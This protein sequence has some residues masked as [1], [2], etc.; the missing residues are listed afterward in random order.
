MSAVLTGTPTAIVWAAGSDPVGQSITIPSDCTAVYMFWS[1]YTGTAGR[2]LASSTLNSLS[3]DEVYEQA[4]VDPDDNATGVAIWYNPSTGSQTLD[5]AWDGA[6]SEGPG[7][8]V[9]YVKGGNTSASRDIDAAAGDAADA[10][11]VTLTTVSG[12]LVLKYDRKFNAIPDLT[13]GWTSAQTENPSGQGNRLSYISATGSTQVCAAE[14]INDYSSIVAV[15]IQAATVVVRGPYTPDT[16]GPIFVRKP[17]TKQPPAGTKIDW[18]YPILGNMPEATVYT[19]DGQHTAHDRGRGFALAKVS[20]RDIWKTVT[21]GRAGPARVLDFSSHDGNVDMFA[22]TPISNLADLTLFS[23]FQADTEANDGHTLICF[24]ES[25]ALTSTGL[26]FL[27]I[28]D[29]LLRYGYRASDDGAQFYQAVDDASLVDDE[30]Y[31]AIGC[32]TGSDLYL[33]IFGL[34]V[35][36]YK[37]LSQGSINTSTVQRQ[38]IS[39]GGYIRSGSNFSFGKSIAYSGFVNGRAVTGAQ[40]KD[41]GQN[42]YQIFKPREIFIGEKPNQKLVVF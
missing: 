34:T 31:A 12:D 27:D 24:S 21:I 3:P 39:I 14:P 17:W 41:W 13:S 29:G 23:V 40:A 26:D 6:P 37:A 8:I 4:E 25:D 5:V 36:Y 11:S 30:W 20:A 33:W 35:D 38:H 7:T 1:Y 9:A 28:E 2:G 42:P 32:R 22:D 15:T 16:D 10:V 18:K 19:F